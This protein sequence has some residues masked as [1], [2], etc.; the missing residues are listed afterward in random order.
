MSDVVSIPPGAEGLMS[1]AYREML[2]VNRVAMVAYQAALAAR[3]GSGIPE[4]IT[5]DNVIT[6]TLE[7]I[8]DPRENLAEAKRKHAAA[9]AAVAKVKNGRERARDRLDSHERDMARFATL[10]SRIQTLLIERTYSDSPDS[11]DLPVAERIALD[12]RRKLIE[13]TEMASRALVFMDGE[14]ALVE[15]E[16]ARTDRLL[17]SAASACL[18]A[19]APELVEK[20]EALEV[21][22]LT[23][24]Q[25]IRAL[26]DANLPGISGA[27]GLPYAATLLLSAP[28][29]ETTRDTAREAALRIEHTRLMADDD[30]AVAA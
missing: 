9:A 27:L 23:V 22:L 24:R 29:P 18:M 14:L 19:R 8:G 21:E 16:A 4:A 1:P 28:R 7:P 11:G 15:A 26:A 12:E 25:D 17:R 6:I 10:D 2:E 30:G 5:T 20:A 3:S 13:R